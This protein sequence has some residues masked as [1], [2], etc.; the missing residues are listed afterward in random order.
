M[1][2]GGGICDRGAWQGACVV[3]GMCMSVGVCM[4]GW[5]VWQG[6]FIA[7]ETTTAADAT[8]PTGM[9]SCFQH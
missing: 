3:G 9:H 6:D 8:H 4:A 7:E 2:G 1:V 5:H